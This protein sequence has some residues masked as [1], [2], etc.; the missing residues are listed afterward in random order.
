LLVL[1]A[2]AIFVLVLTLRFVD[3]PFSAF[4]LQDR[5][6]V[7]SGETGGPLEYQWMPWNAISPHLR[8]AVIASE[9]QKFPDHPGFDVDAIRS[10][11]EAR[12]G[13]DAGDVAMRGASTISQQVAKNLFLWPGRS[14]LRKALEAGFTVL[15][16][17][18]W[19]KRRILEV[20]LNVAQFGDDVYGAEAA[21][22]RYFRKPGAQLNPHEA[23]LMAAVLPNPV[24]LSIAR[25]S[26]YVRERQRWI[27]GQMRQLGGTGFLERIAW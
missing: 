23:A 26:A 17:A 14:W 13:E 16:E 10:V 19:S 15:I 12:L 6:F 3:P 8:L 20:Y 5:F 11:L 27:L 22:G 2:F 21:A 25:P 1:T 4:M 9:D 18:L 7:Q 24:R